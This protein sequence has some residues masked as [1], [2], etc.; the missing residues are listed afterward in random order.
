M[1]A[2]LKNIPLREIML[3][4][5][6]GILIFSIV[7]T[8]LSYRVP[9]Y[10]EETLTT[11]SVKQI[12]QEKH[13]FKVRPSLIYDYKE[14]LDENDPVY[15][16][17]VRSVNM[18]VYYS[19][20]SSR[21]MRFVAGYYRPFLEINSSAGWSKKFW[22]SPPTNFTKPH[23]SMNVALNITQVL[24]IVEK[25]GS[26]VGAK[27]H[28][29]AAA[30]GFYVVA[31]VSIGD[32][33]YTVWSRPAL[34]MGF[35]AESAELALN[36]RSDTHDVELTHVIRRENF[37]NILM[38]RLRI[39]DA[40]VAGPLT[41]L[42]SGALLVFMVLRRNPLGFH[43]DVV[44]K[45]GEIVVD[46]SIKKRNM[47]FTVVEVNDFSKLVEFAEK[48]RRPIVHIL[49]NRGDEAVHRYLLL[50]SD[51]VYEYTHREGR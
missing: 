32:K 4:L 46:G 21:P 5:L 37:L 35:D 9:P 36:F 33:N 44:R 13:M 47:E 12:V 25:L 7:L 30:L 24:E 28:S 41:I 45:Y 31:D 20:S 19:I 3:S 23:A 2:V 51:V 29:F 34:Y 39:E 48:L 50:D 22:L 26:E 38:L 14:V 40:R 43:E 16:N 11:L 1:K 15:R 6:L 17:L 8:V 49:E 27:S 42:S 18:T 10:S